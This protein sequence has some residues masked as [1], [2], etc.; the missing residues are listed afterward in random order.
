MPMIGALYI[1]IL[2]L[3]WILS[4][5]FAISGVGAANTLI[6]I[7]YSFGIPFSIAA[8]AGLLLNV[9]SLS[10][11]TA[12]NAK[13]SFILWKIGVI[14]LIPAVAMAPV[15]AMVGVHT[16]RKYLLIIFVVFLSY[17]LFNLISGRKKGKKDAVLTGISGAITGIFIGALAGFLGG[18]L[19]VGGG[20]IILPVLT[21]MES[22]YKKIAGTSAFIALFS[23]ASGFL[24]YLAI[25]RGVN[26]LLW[27]VVL[28]GGI[29]GGFTGSFLMHRFDSRKVRLLIIIIILFVTVKTAYSVS[30]M[31]H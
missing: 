26:Y 27:I 31:F 12:N 22:D 19:G 13:H 9:F 28:I 30:M 25:L 10:S 24:S 2:I 16:P 8:A 14:F 21:F 29:A 4:A 23:S 7:Y 1:I 6:P 3:T 17:T 18:L 11:A 20:M 5:V 15:G